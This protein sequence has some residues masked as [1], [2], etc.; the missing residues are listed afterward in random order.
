MVSS[1]LVYAWGPCGPAARGRAYDSELQHVVE[2]LTCDA[3]AFGC[4]TTRS[5]RY[6][7]TCGFDVVDYVMLDWTIGSAGLSQRRELGQKWVI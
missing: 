2:F 3:K 4:D 5:S 7:W 1:R 6:G